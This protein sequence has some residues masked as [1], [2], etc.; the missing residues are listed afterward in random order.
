[1][2]NIGDELALAVLKGITEEMKYSW[3]ENAELRNQ[4]S[5]KIQQA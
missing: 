1:M 5:L 3:N 2:I 4:L